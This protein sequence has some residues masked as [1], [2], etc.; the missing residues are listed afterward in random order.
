MKTKPI[1]IFLLAPPPPAP[2]EKTAEEEPFE[3]P[4]LEEVAR[5]TGTLR[6]EP[7]GIEIKRILMGPVR[8]LLKPL[9]LYLGVHSQQFLPKFTK[10][11]LSKTMMKT[12]KNKTR[13]C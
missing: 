13:C 8:L 12:V 2:D 10:S 11:S 3:L 1:K 5:A 4:T 9:C 6:P 7:L